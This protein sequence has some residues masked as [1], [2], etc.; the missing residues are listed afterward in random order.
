MWARSANHPSKRMQQEEAGEEPGNES[1]QL[2]FKLTQNLIKRYRGLTITTDLNEGG[3][4]TARITGVQRRQSMY[5][6]FNLVLR[7]GMC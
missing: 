6:Q 4:M 7:I 3:G 2:N 1:M 5:I